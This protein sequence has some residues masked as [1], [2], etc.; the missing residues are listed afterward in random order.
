MWT[1]LWRRTWPKLEML[2]P[3]LIWIDPGVASAYWGYGY[4]SQN[5]AAIEVAPVS[6]DEWRGLRVA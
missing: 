3:A 1:R 6:A 2:L 4:S 5:E